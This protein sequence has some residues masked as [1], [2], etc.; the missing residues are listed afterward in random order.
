[1]SLVTTCC[2]FQLTAVPVLDNCYPVLSLPGLLGRI[3][4]SE[5]D[6]AARAAVLQAAKQAAAERHQQLMQEHDKVR[7]ELIRGEGGRLGQCV[8]R[9]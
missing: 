7:Q 1:M 2:T 4:V 3:E 9:A 6:P 8:G 5:C